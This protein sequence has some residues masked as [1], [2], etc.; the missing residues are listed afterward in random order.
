MRVDRW[1][2]LLL[3][4]ALAPVHGE[5]TLHFGAR[6]ERDT[7]VL[8]SGDQVL[9]RLRQRDAAA[10]AQ[11]GATL[12]TALT[13]AAERGLGPHALSLGGKPPTVLL[14]GSALLTITGELAQRCDSTPAALAE[15]VLHVLGQALSGPYLSATGLQVP[16]DGAATLPVRGQPVGASFQVTEPAEALVDYALAPDFSRVQLVGR[17]LGRCSLELARGGAKLRVP[18][19]VL[20]SAARV[21]GAPRLTLTGSDDPAVLR[22]ALDGALAACLDTARG[23]T[24]TARPPATLPTGR[25]DL[26]VSVRAP[27]CL[28]LETNLPLVVQRASAPSEV[29]GRLLISN[30]PERADGPLLLLRAGLPTAT[31]TRL[32]YHHVNAAP[33]PLALEVR[34]VNGG[35]APAR[36]H[37]ALSNAG[38]TPDEI[39]CGHAATVGYWLRR[40]AGTGYVVTLPPRTAWTLTA[41]AFAPRGVLSGLGE[42]TVLDGARV[43]LQVVTT[44]ADEA[45]CGPRPQSAGAAPP[46]DS[47]VL[48]K[49]RLRLPVTWRVGGQ[50][51]KLAIG[52]AG[53]KTAAGTELKGNYGV[54]YDCELTFENPTAEAHEVEFVCSP[55]GGVARMVYLLDGEV[56]ETGLMAAFSEHA[57][58]GFMLPPGGRKECRFSV[59]PQAGCS[60]PIRFS[61]REATGTALP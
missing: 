18:V 1:V 31:R 2:R 44:P 48:D 37:V 53:L 22:E 57:L 14:D 6:A 25:V 32:L 20:P 61:A 11:L 41:R 45:R 5:S 24:L 60:Y 49:P 12:V 35:D 43:E 4:F 52:E 42:L 19:E 9:L 50:P 23:A 33:G 17:Q 55:R 26:P 13:A 30:E 8:T 58:F 56:G 21:L 36:V 27:G 39:Y 54:E 28:P 10:A 51:L 46:R 3:V 16:L 47:Q 34:V 59:L 7:A 38:P 40:R 15:T 29:A